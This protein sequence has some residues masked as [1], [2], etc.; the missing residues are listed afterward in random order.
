MLVL[1]MHVV[2][3]NKNIYIISCIFAVR[4]KMFGYFHINLLPE[5]I[6]IPVL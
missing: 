4:L 1:G 6:L 3:V 2:R 5:D